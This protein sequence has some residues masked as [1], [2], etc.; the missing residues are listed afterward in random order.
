MHK[1]VVPEME[2]V[3]ALANV[4]RVTGVRVADGQEIPVAVQVMIT[5]PLP[6]LSPDIFVWVPLAPPL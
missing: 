6:E 3:L 5:M 4:V 2:P 1:G